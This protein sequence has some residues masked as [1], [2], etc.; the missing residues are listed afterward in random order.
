[1]LS[2][3]LFSV[4]VGGIL[5]AVSA[6]GSHGHGHDAGG[7]GDHAHH[8]H[9]GGNKIL[10]LR[11]LTYF[12][13][14]FGGVGGALSWQWNVSPFVVFPIALLSGVGIAGLVAS[15][16][17]YLARTDS[18]SRDGEESFV[19]L[20]GRIVLP[21]GEAGVGKVLVKRG[22]RTYELLA[23]PLDAS[24]AGTRNWEIGRAHV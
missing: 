14:V 1:M 4:L 11:T 3:Y 18:G 23:R 20:A 15:T 10:S 8:D 16:F 17:R 12:L 6:F 5:L 13:F 2:L 9:D 22:D 19:G 7:G 24:A 21:I